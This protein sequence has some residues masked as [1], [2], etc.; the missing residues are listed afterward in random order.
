MD[1]D[2]LSRVQV[3]IVI[4]ADG[5]S[6]RT[7]G[8]L[9]PATLASRGTSA[10]EL[11]GAYPDAGLELYRGMRV[12]RDPVTGRIQIL[13]QRPTEIGGERLQAN[14]LNFSDTRSVAEGFAERPGGNN[15]AGDTQVVLVT[16]PITR[17]ESLRVLHESNFDPRIV[18]DGLS[19]ADKWDMR[20][21]VHL[22]GVVHEVHVRD[23]ETGTYRP[24]RP[25]EVEW[26]NPNAPARAGPSC[27]GCTGAGNA[28]TATAPVGGSEN[29]A[30][31][32][33]DI[34]LAFSDTEGRPVDAPVAP[35]TPPAPADAR[36][37]FDRARRA[38]GSQV[39]G[40]VYAAGGSVD[41]PTFY[42]MTPEGQYLGTVERVP[43][44]AQFGVSDQM[45]TRGYPDAPMR[46]LAT[47]PDGQRYGLGADGVAA[48]EGD[49]LRPLTPAERAALPRTVQNQLMQ[50][51][52]G[53]ALHTPDGQNAGWLA[54]ARTGSAVVDMATNQ[55]DAQAAGLAIGSDQV[56]RR[57]DSRTPPLPAD[58][59]RPRR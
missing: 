1:P 29:P 23:A 2:S 5:I 56:G 40:V 48:V 14:I 26:V 46:R 45:L 36:E 32:L 38:P 37:A 35:A 24:A 59:A 47:G 18:E 11:H 55:H 16:R 51:A 21:D 52:A 49:R 58:G 27:P 25:G 7:G 6:R 19:T 3:P 20:S 4:E 31:S 53:P 30:T 8:A 57:I 28:P 39:D 12:P 22:P 17:E 13:E 44:A 15:F 50:R 9:S 34:G 42:R 33:R 43:T 54:R 10:A 41:D